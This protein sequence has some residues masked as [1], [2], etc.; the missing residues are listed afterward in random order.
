[1][2][3]LVKIETEINIKSVRLELHVRYGKEDMPDDFPLRQGDMWR[4]TVNIDNGEIEGWPKGKSGSFFMK[5]CDEGSYYL[6][7]EDGKQIAKRE[8][9]YVPHGVIP[10]K[11][12]DYVEMKID[13]NG[14]ITNWPKPPDVSDFFDIAD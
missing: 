4:A 9:D 6:L 12:G 11:Y 3:A 13:D 7:G 1:M 5:V 2:K 10:G 8:E 14:I